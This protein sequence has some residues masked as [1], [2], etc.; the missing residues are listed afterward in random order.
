LKHYLRTLTRAGVLLFFSFFV[1]VSLIPGLCP[2]ASLTILHTNDTHSHLLPFSYPTAIDPCSPATALAR[3]PGGTNIGGIARRATLV[4]QIK[5][6]LEAKGTPVWLVDA[7]DFSDGTLFSIEYRGEADV[8]A[9]NAAGYDFAALGNHEFIYPL[10]QTRTLIG[11]ARFPI[12][13]ANALL[14]TTKEPLAQVYRVEQAGPIRVGI[15]GLITSETRSYPAAKEG[16]SIADPVRTAEKV[17]ARLHAEKADIIVLISHCG[18]EM[19][20]QLASMVPGIDVIVGGHS[21]SRL[22]SGEFIPRT[23]EVVADKIIGTIIVQAYQWGGELGR[24]DLSFKKDPAGAWHVDRYRARLIPVTAAIEPDAGVA[25]VVDRYW[26]PIAP[27]YAEVIG[28]AVDDFSSRCEDWAEYNLMADAIRETFGTEIELENIGGV[29]SPLL[30]GKITRG[31]LV[32]LDPFANTVVTFKITGRQLRKVLARYAPAVSGVRYR[33][34]NGELIEALVN[35][36]PLQDNRRYTGTTNSYF[37][38]R[39]FKGVRVQFHDTGKRR[40][41]VLINYIRQKGTIRPVFDG[42]RVVIGEPPLKAR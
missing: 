42:R 12:L 36:E 25:A 18:E 23:E 3:L 26:R 31:D 1:L 22:P 19:D 7:G 35:G 15:F 30:K 9:M 20:K 10:A 6:E 32:A 29:R 27:R 16:V 33:L 11:L 2:A 41:E 4:K 28:E 17:V 34:E 8:A 21:H 24:C 14:K 37:A 38:G 40:L 39:V 5:S 13:C